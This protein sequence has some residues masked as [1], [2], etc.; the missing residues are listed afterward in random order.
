MQQSSGIKVSPSDARLPESLS[1]LASAPVAGQERDK[2]R[3]SLLSLGRHT[4]CSQES[5]SS[6]FLIVKLTD[7]HTIKSATF[8]MGLLPNCLD[9]EDV[10]ADCCLL[11]GTSLAPH[12]LVHGGWR[13]M[14]LRK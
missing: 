12:R 10:C 6:E 13:Q 14:Y 9:S 4:V 5:G 3:T 7:M 2:G 11:R 1:F 8:R